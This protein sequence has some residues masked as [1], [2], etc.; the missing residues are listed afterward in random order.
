MDTNCGEFVDE[1]RAEQWMKRVEVGQTIKILG[2]EFEI[3]GISRREMTVKLLSYEDRML[4]SL[5]GVC[6]EAALI[7]SERHRKK[8]LSGK[9]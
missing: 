8:M 2:E 4:G 1:S 9:G 5:A 7:E 6:D 3:T